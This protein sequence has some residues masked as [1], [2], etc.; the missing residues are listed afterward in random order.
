MVVNHAGLPMGIV[1]RNRI[2]Y[3]IFQKLG[4]NLSADFISKF[5]SKNKYPLGIELPRIIELMKRKGDI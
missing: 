2:G 5:K 4:I 1:D 3:F